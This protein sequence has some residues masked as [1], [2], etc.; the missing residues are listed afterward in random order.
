MN[1]NLEKDQIDLIDLIAPLWKNRYFIS[2]TTFL[3]LLMLYMGISIYNPINKTNIFIQD[4][5]FR[6]G[7]LINVKTLINNSRIEQAIKELELDV[8]IE[9]INSSI[10]I[11]N[12]TITYSQL[13]DSF[14]GDREKIINEIIFKAGSREK[15][16][17]NL[18]NSL[19]DYKKS[20]YQIILNGNLLSNLDKRRLIN[21]L[22]E[23]FNSSSLNVTEG[24]VRLK[25]TALATEENPSIIR[26]ESYINKLHKAQANF[27]IF[28]KNYS[29]MLLSDTDNIQE[30]LNQAM[31]SLYRYDEILKKKKI[32][33][34]NH[35]IKVQKTLVEELLK[36][37]IDF[38]TNNNKPSNIN[39]DLSISD[40]TI[41]KL[42]NIGEVITGSDIK[43][44]LLEKIVSI[45]EEVGLLETELFDFNQNFNEA[46]TILSTEEIVFNINLV[47]TIINKNVEFI[48]QHINEDIILLNGSAVL[49]EIRVDNYLNNKLLIPSGI[50]FIIL[51]SL[52]S[53][54]RSFFSNRH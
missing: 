30:K 39:G 54:I 36:L 22:V 26:S 34:L 45:N 16:I 28:K 52:M 35:K 51:I 38:T 42:I 46:D 29:T 20:A 27:K 11:I 4:F 37:N 14:S 33:R 21:Y 13:M 3:F 8:S 48:N 12:S 49:E 19:Y 53:I 15:D 17:V 23:D 43:K 2:I 7:E 41:T 32:K 6:G 44:M 10:E 24:Y 50:V 40:D 25:T 47:L 5:T 1:Q 31:F 18:W 9:N